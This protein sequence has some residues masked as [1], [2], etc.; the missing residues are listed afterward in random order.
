MAIDVYKAWLGIPE[1]PR[2]PDHYT[3]LRL[4][5]FEDDVDKVS[6]NYKKLNGHVRKYASG[7]YRI[8]SQELLTE[9]AKAMLCLTDPERK[10][11]L[12]ESMGRVFEDD[13]AES[14]RQPMERV[15]VDQGHI[16]RDQMK[17]VHE[18]AERRGL[19]MHDA[20]VQMKLAD[21][22]TAAQAL[23]QELGLSYVDLSEMAPD[24]SVLDRV[25]RS[26][27]KRNTIL[28]LFLDD[29]VLLVACVDE[30]T[31]E[32]EDELRLRFEV[33]MRRVIASPKAIN[34]GIA[35]YYAAGRRDEAAAAQALAASSKSKA[36]PEKQ[37]KKKPPKPISQLTPEELRQRKL[38]G[39]LIAMWAIVGSVVAGQFLPGANLFVEYLPALIVTPIVIYF[40]VKTYLK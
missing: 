37:K 29:D 7:K 11:E 18:F 15:L 10:R 33:P 4:V 20:V 32:L 6:A 26:L 1:G 38:I 19:E 8:E 22:E 13:G 30:P 25:P 9:L 31:H 23:A 28:P 36:K 16:T 12:D 2:P 17:E 14:G 21:A 39:A 34:Q 24:D 3:L 40:F 35:K 27:V 5:K